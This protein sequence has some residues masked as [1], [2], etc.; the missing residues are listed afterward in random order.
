MPKRHGKGFVYDTAKITPE[1]KLELGS[2][3]WIGDFVFVNLESLRIGKGSQVGAFASLTGGGRVEIG[4]F[5]TV[6]YGV[7]VISGTDTTEGRYM[8]DQA[9]EAE[10]NV[11]R[12][13]V[14]IGSRCFIGANAV[15]CVSER[16]PNIEI[17]SDVVIGALSYVDQSVRPNVVGWGAPFRVMKKRKFGS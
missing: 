12:G 4:E 17:G 11:V 6:G 7:R 13:T 10:R 15:V 16:E 3:A 2:D 1:T 14:K 5:T 8:A 9:P